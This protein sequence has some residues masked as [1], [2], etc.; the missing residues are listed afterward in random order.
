M[1]VNN[2]L[3]I[4]LARRHN[5]ARKPPSDHAAGAA[6]TPHRAF[7]PLANERAGTPDGVPAPVVR[8][9]PKDQNL[10]LAVMAKRRPSVS[11]VDGYVLPLLNDVEPMVLPTIGGCLL[12]M[13]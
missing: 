12:N 10:S 7:P 6:R 3:L 8:K 11:Y 1:I 13:F 5:Q 4:D 9:V 2:P